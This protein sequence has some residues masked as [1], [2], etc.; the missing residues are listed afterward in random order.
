ML[1]LVQLP[2]DPLS[3]SE[4]FDA[5][6]IEHGRVTM[7]QRLAT[8]KSLR[9]QRTLQGNHYWSSHAASPRAATF[10]TPSW[11][12]VLPPDQTRPPQSGKQRFTRPEE[13]RPTGHWSIFRSYSIG[14]NHRWRPGMLDEH[15]RFGICLCV[16]NI[17]IAVAYRTAAWNSDE[18]PLVVKPLKLII[19]S[20]S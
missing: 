9:F 20:L 8:S 14:A 1:V 16:D 13:L 12:P 17:H 5:R 18:K 3:N 2:V 11:R 19:K 10:R 6:G 4:A 15:L 7:L